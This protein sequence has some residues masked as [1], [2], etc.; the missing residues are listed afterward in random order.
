MDVGVVKPVETGDGDAA[1]LKELAELPEAPE[2][3]AG[4]SFSAA[5]APLVA[6]RLEGADLGLQETVGRVRELAGRHAF[7]V[8]EGAGGLLVP[9]GPGWTI[10][11]L[12][13]ALGLPLLVVA[14][15]GLGTVNHTCLTV[16]H[17][18]RLGL[19]VHG[20]VL[21]GRAD[22]STEAN[23]ELIE[24]FGHVGVLAQVPWLD[25]EI[26]PE[27]LRRLELDLGLV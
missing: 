27:R 24:S 15:A 7:A 20:V 4:F 10:A 6:A 19:E 5:V 14:R 18:R 13:L 26:T 2:E 21:N 23:A 16:A 12:A 17:A 3:I 25:G 1:T 9:V 8:V 11:D 22:E